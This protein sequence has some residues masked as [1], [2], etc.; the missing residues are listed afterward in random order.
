MLLD[1]S[2]YLGGVCE[3]LDQ[4]FDARWRLEGCVPLKEFYAVVF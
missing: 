1:R 2:S 4:L 3:Y